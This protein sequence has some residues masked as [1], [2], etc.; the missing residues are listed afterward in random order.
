MENNIESYNK[1]LLRFKFCEAINVYKLYSKTKTLL[2]FVVYVSNVK[3]DL[4]SPSLPN[5]DMAYTL[6]S[7]N[8]Y[9]E[10]K[11]GKLNILETV[12]PGK[13]QLYWEVCYLI[14]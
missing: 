6:F 5:F 14:H 9:Q 8:K 4:P 3:S 13:K 1:F 2:V 12:E 7:I 11:L 10:F